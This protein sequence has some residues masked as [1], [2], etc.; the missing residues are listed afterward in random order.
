MVVKKFMCDTCGK[1]VLT[2][3]SLKEINIDTASGMRRRYAVCRKCYLDII[4]YIKN[5]HKT[6]E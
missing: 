6:K 2:Y 4:K 5:I 3:N 1:E